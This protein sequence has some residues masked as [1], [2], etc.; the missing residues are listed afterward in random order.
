MAD[1]RQRLF[2][3]AA[4]RHPRYQGGGL[5]TGTSA[6]LVAHRHS[7]RLADLKRRAR[8]EVT[9]TL[10]CSGNT[11]LPFFIG[12]IGNARWAGTLARLDPQNVRARWSRRAKWSSGG[13]TPEK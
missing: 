5:A 12:G 6:G 7:L 13:P 2:V 10:E 9:F 11:G 4:L 1:T 3:V 8:Q